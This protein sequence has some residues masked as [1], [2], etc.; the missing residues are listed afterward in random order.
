MEDKVGKL[1]ER[2]PE[3]ARKLAKRIAFGLI[4]AVAVLVVR[5]VVD[6][7]W[8]RITGELPPTKVEKDR[9]IENRR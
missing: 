3:E 8:E 1:S 5:K 6:M 4:S 9:E 2:A 7:L